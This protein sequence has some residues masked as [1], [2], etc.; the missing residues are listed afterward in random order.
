MTLGHRTF[1]EADAP[2]I[3]A[4]PTSAEELFFVIPDAVYPLAPSRLVAVAS[5]SHDPTVG[6]LNGRLAGYVGFVE[7]HPRKFCT[8]GN[9]VVHPE[10]RRQGIGSYLVSTM[11]Q[12][13][14]DQYAVRFI[15]VSC[16][17]HNKPAYMLCQ[18]LG[19]RPAGMG[20]HLMGLDADPILIVHMHL[21]KRNWK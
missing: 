3:C 14:F 4:F 6:L 11:V 20:Q 2:S 19:F 10:F 16:F 13:A 5:Q 15:R 17:S 7:A 21:T 12:R 1:R 9:L 8:M 18:K